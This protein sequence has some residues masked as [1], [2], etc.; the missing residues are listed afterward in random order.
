[1]LETY[2]GNVHYQRYH[3]GQRLKKI[4]KKLYVKMKTKQR[5]QR[6]QNSLTLLPTVLRK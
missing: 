3:K 4:N 2:L 6:S 5:E 1:M